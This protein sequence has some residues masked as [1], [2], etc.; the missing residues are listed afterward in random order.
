MAFRDRHRLG[1]SA[2]LRRR[3]S[4]LVVLLMN[5]RMAR[6]TTLY[7]AQPDQISPFE[8]AV[9]VL[10]FPECRVVSVVEN[11]AHWIPRLASVV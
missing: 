3:R 9:P 1:G 11:I 10:E 2:R 4:L 7:F 8:V 6:G 5:K